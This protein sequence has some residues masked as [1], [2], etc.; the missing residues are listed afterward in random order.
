MIHEKEVKRQTLSKLVDFVQFGSG[1][2]K[3]PVQEELVRTV[4]INIFCCLPPASH[5]N[6]GSEAADPEEE[7]PFLDPAWPHLQLV[8]ELLLRYVIS[9]DT[10]T[11]VVKQYIDHS[12]FSKRQSNQTQ[13]GTGYHVLFLTNQTRRFPLAKNIW[14]RLKNKDSSYC[15]PYLNARA[16]SR[17]GGDLGTLFLE[18]CSKYDSYQHHIEE[19]Q[20]VVCGTSPIGVILLPKACFILPPSGLWER[21]LI[22]LVQSQSCRR[23]VGHILMVA[24]TFFSCG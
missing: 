1:R 19:A 2:L 8:Y 12:F 6:T 7:D 17:G 10:D 15:W 21:A 23:G 13:D 22:T 9:S 14:S 16:G 5:E 24:M 20:E 11:K 4:G 3:E 18:D